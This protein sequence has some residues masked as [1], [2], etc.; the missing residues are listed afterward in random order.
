[1]KK[2]VRI[3]TC[4][5]LII[6]LPISAQAATATIVQKTTRPDY[7]IW[8]AD[9]LLANDK[10]INGSIYGNFRKLQ[11][12]VYQRLGEEIA[13]SKGT[14]ITSGVWSYLF[15]SNYRDYFIQGPEHIYEIILID[16][17]KYGASN[18]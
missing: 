12:T 4:I 18:K 8:F 1:M 9:Q 3:I 13:R 6:A 7:Y 14:T 15:N 2:I 11:Q 16:Y 17:L 5:I 10:S